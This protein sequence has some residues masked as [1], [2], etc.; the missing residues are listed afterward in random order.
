MRGVFYPAW[1]PGLYR[2]SERPWR[3][4]VIT[5]GL[6]NLLEMTGKAHRWEACSGGQQSTAGEMNSRLA[7]ARGGGRR[8]DRAAGQSEVPFS[9]SGSPGGG[10]PPRTRSWVASAEQAPAPGTHSWKPPGAR[11]SPGL[12][13]RGETCAIGVDAG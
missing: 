1:L 6:R 13:F 10:R 9:R 3:R 4:F 2:V 8:R 11:S 7:S 5:L 12:G